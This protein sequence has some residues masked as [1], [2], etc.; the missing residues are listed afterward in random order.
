MKDEGGRMKGGR[1]KGGRM[2]G[3]REESMESSAK[4]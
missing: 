3:G 2:K 4:T 1:M